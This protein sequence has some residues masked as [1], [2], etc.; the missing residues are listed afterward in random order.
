MKTIN[1]PR[2]FPIC[3]FVSS[4]L[5]AVIVWASILLLNS[6]LVVAEAEK[7]AVAPPMPN[8]GAYMLQVLLGLLFVIGLVFAL[9]WILKRVGQGTLVASQQMKVVAAL[10]MGTR[11]RIALVEVGGQHLLL[12]ITPTQINTLHVF[13]EPVDLEAAGQSSTSEFSVKLKEILSR[14][15][16]KS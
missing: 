1:M 8:Q 9:A 14:G 10:P 2:L 6:S 12:G 5:R 4:R 7:N 3:G 15:S 13:D 11:E 16:V